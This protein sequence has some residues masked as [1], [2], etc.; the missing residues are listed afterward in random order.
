M[1]IVRRLSDWGSSALY[2]PNQWGVAS[3]PR[4]ERSYK[5]RMVHPG[6]DD[7][8]LGFANPLC[9]AHDRKWIGDGF[10]HAQTAHANA[11]RAHTFRQIQDSS[12]RNNFI[13]KAS[14]VH[15]GRDPAQHVLGPGGAKR[16]DDVHDFNHVSGK[17]F[18]DL[19]VDQN[20]LGRD[21]T[22]ISIWSPLVL[23]MTIYLEAAA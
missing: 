21:A 6:V 14:A 16:G 23:S 20:D 13:F 17:C 4:R 19:E 3:E 18:Y 22:R 15:P 5:I 1:S 12:Q 11:G 8:G 2:A 9:Q 7:V 10:L